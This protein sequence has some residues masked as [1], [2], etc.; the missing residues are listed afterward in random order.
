[1]GCDPARPDC[2]IGC[3]NLIDSMY[4]KC[5]GVCM[6]DG[7]YYDPRKIYYCISLKLLKL[8]INS[9]FSYMHYILKQFQ[10]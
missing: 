9:L 3:Q 8:C 2:A 5:D 4:I 10:R 6:P 1:M 7:Y